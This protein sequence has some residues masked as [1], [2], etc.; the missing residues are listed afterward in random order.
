MKRLSKSKLNEYFNWLEHVD[1]KE[2]RFEATQGLREHIMALELELV[3][4]KK[5]Q[6][7]P[8]TE[9]DIHRTVVH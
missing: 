1:E 2:I 5:K 4:E 3:A 6:G 7:L 9:S 8:V